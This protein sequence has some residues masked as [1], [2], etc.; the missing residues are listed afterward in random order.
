MKQK[1]ET[2]IVSKQCI[3]NLPRAL[4]QSPQL[5]R[6]CGHRL[7]ENLKAENKLRTEG[8]QLHNRRENL[9]SHQTTKSTEHARLGAKP[10]QPVGV[11][12][13]SSVSTAEREDSLHGGPEVS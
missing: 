12:V 7:R 5:A 6:F 8:S 11:S 10:G 4:F 2:T 3:L 9:R 1:L 13:F